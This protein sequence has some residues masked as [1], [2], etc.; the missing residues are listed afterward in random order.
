MLNTNLIDRFK[1]DTVENAPEGEWKQLA[2]FL[3]RGIAYTGIA[4][5]VGVA[6]M[7]WF[8]FY[9]VTAAWRDEKG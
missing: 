5:L 9:I 4:V 7:L 8:V 2:W 6:V 3:W 1:A